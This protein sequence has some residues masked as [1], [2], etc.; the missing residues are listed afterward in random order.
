M[1]HFR[2]NEI[3]LRNAP[4]SFIIFQSQRAKV[5]EGCLTKIQAPIPCNGCS[6]VNYCSPN[7]Q[8]STDPSHLHQ[9]LGECSILKDIGP[10]RYYLCDD[11]R[12]IL[13][14]YLADKVFGSKADVVPTRPKKMRGFADLMD[15]A[16][17]IGLDSPNILI[18]LWTQL[19]MVSIPQFNSP[20]W[21]TFVSTYGKILTNSYTIIDEKSGEKLAKALY[22]G[23]SYFDHSCQ[24]NARPRFDGFSLELLAMDNIK[25]KDDL[26]NVRIC[27]VDVNQTREE[28]NKELEAIWYFKCDCLRCNSE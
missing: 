22:L 28:I 5:C 17:E 13:R 14:T 2:K 16:T 23:G 25:A 21:S 10:L 7:C 11:V 3:I 18:E 12:M 19:K 15:H 6:M 8:N 9:T 4:F 26:R 24:P 1:V 20:S 27:Y